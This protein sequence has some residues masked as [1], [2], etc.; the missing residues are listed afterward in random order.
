MNELNSQLQ[1][2]ST[3]MFID[4]INYVIK[5]LSYQKGN[6]IFDTNR[7]IVYLNLS[8]VKQKYFV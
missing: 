1:I 5:R 2:N 4:I 3:G 6:V 7:I 8:G